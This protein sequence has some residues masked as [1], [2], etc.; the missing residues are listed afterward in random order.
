MNAVSTNTLSS[1]VRAASALV[2][3]SYLIVGG[4]Q[5]CRAQS[6]RTT[7]ATVAGYRVRVVSAA[8]SLRELARLHESLGVPA[9]SGREK[10]YRGSELLGVVRART[11]AGVRGA[12]PPIE[13]VA[14]KSGSTLDVDNRWLHAELMLYEREPASTS[15]RAATLQRLA[16]RL[17]SLAERLRELE[18]TEAAATERRDKDAEKGRLATI[19]RGPEYAEK[20]AHESALDRILETISKW[21]RDLLPSWGPLRPGASGGAVTLAQMLIYT[22]IA[23]VLFLVFRWY[24]RRRR[25]TGKKSA[26]GREPR[27]ILGEQ[28]AAD[29]TAADLLAAAERLAQTGNL[30]GAIRKAYIALLCELGDRRVLRIAQ[31][32]T[33]RDYLAAV[34]AL[35]QLY[36]LLHPLTQSFERHWYGLEA[37]TEDDWNN[38]R[39]TCGQAL[40]V[41]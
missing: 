25:I 4:A 27:V 15:D 13:R 35:P 10:I 11:L 36:G 22:L 5:M 30:R 28:L 37:A 41:K 21:I 32:K 1:I 26:A 2:F 7:T 9:N 17:H 24:W 39:S 33:N 19:L 38:F 18:E 16:E 23:A 40:S 8:E 31:H 3:A 20:R 14:F 34:R 6:H 12:L 29:Q